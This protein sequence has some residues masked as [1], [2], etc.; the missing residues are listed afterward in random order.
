MAGTGSYVA[1]LQGGYNHVFKSHWMLGFETD[2]SFP[3][4]DVV[5]PFSV[6][7]SQTVTSPLTGQVTYGEA[8]IYSGTARA[9]FGY[10]FDHF[11]L[12]GTGGLAWTFD[13]VTRTQIAGSPAVG[14]ATPGTVD[15]SQPWRVGW[16]AGAGVE[17]PLS[18]SWTAKAEYL[19]TGFGH[20]SETFA[21]GAQ[22]FDSDLAMQSIRLGLNYRIGDTTPE[23]V[24]FLTKGPSALETDRFAF[25]G[26]FTYLNQ[27]DPAFRAPYG[28]HEQSGPEHRPRDRRRDTVCGRPALAGR[29]SLDQSGNRSG[30]WPERIGRRCRIPE[31]RGLQGRSGQS[32][33]APAT[34]LPTTD[35]RP[36]RRRPESRFR[37]QPV[38]RIA[39]LGPAGAHG[40]KNRRGRYLRH[41]QI[42]PR[43]PRRFHELVAR[44]HRHV[45][46]R[47]GC[48]GLYGRRRRGMVHRSVDPARRCVRR[49]HR[50]QRD[51]AWIR[52]SV[53]S[54]R[55]GKSSG[56]IPSGIS[57]ANWR[58]PDF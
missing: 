48:L 22:A 54:S 28:G 51:H 43:S 41:Q 30:F 19:W 1:G 32:L 53:S 25:H 2:L 38:F 58:S 39:D 17:I 6:R 26:Q 23:G 7:G 37:T 18:G 42:R 24:D 9:R 5:I 21:A 55:S 12:Y 29:R 33:Y 56:G 34:G 3:N 31:R 46:L 50:P 40:R 49:F 44:R 16:A 57:P 20:H 52:R 45:R 10:A 14:S 4:S 47:G 35:D 27:Y 36:R 15:T 8:E 13:Q 11:L